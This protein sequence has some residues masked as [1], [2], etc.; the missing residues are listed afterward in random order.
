MVRSLTATI[1]SEYS[2]V[3]VWTWMGCLARSFLATWIQTRDQT[4][5]APAMTSEEARMTLSNLSPQ[6]KLQ[7]ISLL[8]HNLTVAARGWYPGQTDDEKAA[9]KLRVFNE[10]LHTVSAKLMALASG[11][12]QRF[13][14]QGFL[15]VLFEKAQQEHCESDLLQA[16][17][18]SC[19]ARWE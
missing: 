5:E 2:A 15:D 13:P 16:I 10:L 9:R 18:Y 4:V 11:D 1:E 6:R 7:V 17:A 8:A 3:V 14:D 19:S 12:P